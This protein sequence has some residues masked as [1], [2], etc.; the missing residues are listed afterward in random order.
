MKTEIKKACKKTV[1]INVGDTF[2]VNS[3]YSE[4]YQRIS[5]E[6]GRKALPDKRNAILYAVSLNNGSVSYAADLSNLVKVTPSS[7]VNGVITFKDIN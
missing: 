4:I 3:E 2:R 5:G 6:Q 7:V 1:S